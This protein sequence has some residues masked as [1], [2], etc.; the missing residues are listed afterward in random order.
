MVGSRTDRFL[1]W[2]VIEVTRFVELIILFVEFIVKTVE[3]HFV[4][5]LIVVLIISD[6]LLARNLGM[7][8]T[9]SSKNAKFCLIL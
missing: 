4:E 8:V 1:V 6:V 3:F 7:N 2:F 5:N 9:F